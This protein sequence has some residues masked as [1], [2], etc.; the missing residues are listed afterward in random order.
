LEICEYQV[1]AA[2]AADIANTERQLKQPILT[3]TTLEV[4]PLLLDKINLQLFL[5][6]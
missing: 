2:L 5:I 4:K 1:S 3:I 6:L